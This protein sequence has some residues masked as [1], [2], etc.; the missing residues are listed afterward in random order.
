MTATKQKK[1]I[2]SESII[3]IIICSCILAYLVGAIVSKVIDKNNYE[4]ELAAK[5]SVHNE[6]VEENSVLNELNS[7]DDEA[8]LAEDYA[9]QNGYVMPDEHVYVDATPGV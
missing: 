7:K 5:Q 3:A 8:E 9:R 6:I 1:K 2:R 4:K